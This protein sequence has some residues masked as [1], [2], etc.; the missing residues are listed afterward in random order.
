[1]HVHQ[2]PA[3]V[4]IHK[5]FKLILSEGS[6]FFFFLHTQY[7]STL[8]RYFYQIRLWYV[9]Q[10]MGCFSPLLLSQLADAVA[11]KV[12]SEYFAPGTGLISFTGVNCRGN[13]TKLA[14]CPHNK[15]TYYGYCS[16]HQDVGV[17]CLPTHDYVVTPNT[18]T[19]APEPTSSNDSTS[20]IGGAMGGALIVI[21][22]LL[23]LVVIIAVVVM[24]RKKA[25]VQ[26]LQLEV[27][28]R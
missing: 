25:A 11:I 21:I 19:Y 24:W 5:I 7:L 23:V 6:F 17:I 9:H 4:V 8:A 18:S 15:V 20:V 28:A 2:A 13:E 10:T 14:D 27:L 26:S 1:V 16:H 12:D 3:L 22:L